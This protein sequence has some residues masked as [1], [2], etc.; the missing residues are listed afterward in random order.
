MIINIDGD[1]AAR[2]SHP[3]EGRGQV[4]GETAARHIPEHGAGTVIS[5][6]DSRY[7]GRSCIYVDDLRPT[8]TDVPGP[9]GDRHKV[10]IGGAIDQGSRREAPEPGSV[11]DNRLGQYRSGGI[12]LP[13]NHGPVRLGRPFEHRRGVVGVKVVVGD[14]AGDR[15]EVV[16]NAKDRCRRVRGI[17]VQHISGGGIA[18]VASGI[19]GRDRVAVRRPVEKRRRGIGP[20]AGTED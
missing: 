4:V 13:D 1:S 14:C 9:V 8:A 7:I 6:C 11:V 2:F 3:G 16:G 5:T 10:L 19:G 15:G 20:G 12:G 18:D 17:D